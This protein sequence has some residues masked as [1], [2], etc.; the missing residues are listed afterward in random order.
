M[1]LLSENPLLGLANEPEEN[2]TF[3][4]NFPKF[5]GLGDAFHVNLWFSGG[6]IALLDPD[7]DLACMN[8][9]SHAVCQY[10]SS[11][12]PALAFPQKAL[13]ALTGMGCLHTDHPNCDTIHTNTITTWAQQSL[14]AA[15]HF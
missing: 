1:G 8:I 5:I 12:I 2:I 9:Y 7:G 13:A 3:G 10:I 11:Q 14:V 15:A 4:H 6:P